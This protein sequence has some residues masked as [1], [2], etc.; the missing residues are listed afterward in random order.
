MKQLFVFLF[1][2]NFNA[3]SNVLGQQIE[4]FNVR[5]ASLETCLKKIEQLTGNGFFYNEKE[6]SRVKGISV[7]MQHVDLRSVLTEITKGS[8][9]GFEIIDNVIV[10]KKEAESLVQEETKMVKI[11]GEVK[12]EEGMTLP[13][14]SVLVKGTA[15]GIATNIDGKYDLEIPDV[16]GTVLVFSFVG[17]TSQEVVF[18]GQTT[19]NVV[20]KMAAEALEEVVVTA[21]GIVKQ[22]ASV[23]YAV[24]EV[25]GENLVKARDANAVVALQGRVSGLR[26][27]SSPNLFDDPGV[28]LRGKTLLYV[29]DGVPVSTDMWNISPDDIASYT[30][31]KGPAASALYGSRGKNGAIEI[32]TKKGA[33]SQG[34]VNFEYNTSNVF[35]TGFYA[36]PKSQYKYGPGS[37][38]QYAFVDGMGSG[39]N[40][41][42]YDIWGPKFEGQLIPQWDSPIDPETG[43][44]IPTPWLCKG[45]NN[46][47]NYLQTGVISTH[48]LTIASSGEKAD[49]RFSLSHLYQ[50]GLIPNTDLNSTTVNVGGNIRLSNKM[51]LEGRI[52]Y[53]KQYTDNYTDMSYGPWNPIYTLVLWGSANYDV[54]DLKDYWLPGQEG[55]QQ[56]NIE[57]LRYNNPW[58]VAHEWLRSYHKD[59]VIANLQYFYTINDNLLLK[60]RGNVNTYNLRRSTKMPY[61]ASGYG[62][63]GKAKKGQYT[64]THEG[65]TDVNVDLMLSYRKDFGKFGVN[66]TLGG[67]MF[68]RDYHYN[69]A[70]TASLVVPGLYTFSNSTEP[71]SP[72]N[73]SYEKVLYSGYLSLDLNYSNWI[74]LSATGR[75]DQSS[76]MPIDKNLYFYPS[77]STSF[78]LSNLVEMPHWI[79]MLK[80]RGAWAKVGGDLSSAYS[81][82]PTY[83]AGTSWNNNLPLYYSSTIYNKKLEPEFS[84]TLDLG[85]DL[86]FWDNRI[87][88]EVTWFRTIDG[89]KIFDL[90]LS[91]ASGF[92]TLQENGLKYKRQGWEFTLNTYPVK[93]ADFSWNSVINASTMKETLHEYYGGKKKYGYYY[94]G[95]VSTRFFIWDFERSPDG[96]VVY[97]KAGNPVDND[98]YPIVGGDSRPDM[99][100]GWINTFTYKNFSLTANVDGQIGGKIVNDINASMWRSGRHPNSVHPS[101]DDE[102]EGRKTMIGKGVVVISGSVERD[103]EGRVLSDTR[104]FAPNTT[105]VYYSSWAKNYKAA[106]VNNLMD[107]TFFKLREVMLTYE[108][109]KS[110]LQKTPIKSVSVSV[111]GRNLC[112][113]AKMKNLDLDQYDDYTDTSTNQTPSVRNFGFNLNVKF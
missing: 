32:V 40:D 63:I 83:S 66:S 24:Q 17:M 62:T 4:V 113:W 85:A 72:S 28:T 10:I 48:N 74:Y 78:I 38:G 108:L 67:S 101:R 104:Q 26:V 58:F 39:I 36:I 8:G 19:I 42:D 102:N 105:P 41:A 47:E 23:G 35:Q 37:H 110:L 9:F 71:V 57:Y 69:Y 81:T 30:V 59:D 99:H 49:V 27:T 20:L 76:Y 70:A 100:L 89:P 31:L 93:T 84:T 90:P 77:V 1:L 13:G 61:S 21:M 18:N 51:R 60:A 14:V 33:D 3:F 54:R 97:D 103:A 68:Y 86:R 25:K 22:K 50:K 29:V 107:K 43:E 65:R 79:S 94:V 11:S 88:L 98:S 15:T 52:N 34:K 111:F 73:N 91:E 2:L 109:P 5:N 112:Y 7:H 87:G 45:K 44:R 46:L 56:R 80:V 95:D 82:I 106:T 16:K 55:I 64:E 12:D 75:M 6:I 53:N 92:E 96:Q